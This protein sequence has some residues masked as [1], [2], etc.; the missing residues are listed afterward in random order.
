[1]SISVN[2][3]SD[4]RDSKLM[5][6]LFSNA[7][8]F[9]DSRWPPDRLLLAVQRFLR[10]LIDAVYTRDPLAELSPT[11]ADAAATTSPREQFVRLL[12]EREY[13]PLG[14]VAEQVS[15]AVPTIC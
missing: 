9:Y 3:W 7:L 12:L 6:T 10:L 5:Q 15:W 14:F 13:K 1:M 4:S 8:P 2:V 11:A